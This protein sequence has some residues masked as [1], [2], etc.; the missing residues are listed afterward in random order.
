MGR[1]C[2]GLSHEWETVLGLPGQPV[3]E[4]DIWVKIGPDGEAV[5]W[6]VP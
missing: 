4:T 6:A 3:E 1:P 5:H 2:V